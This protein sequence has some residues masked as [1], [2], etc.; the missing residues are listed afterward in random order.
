MP[1]PI[2]HYQHTQVGY[3]VIFALAFGMSLCAG[4]LLAAEFNA[5]ALGMVILLGIC[6]WLFAMLT[7]TVDNRWLTIRFGPGLVR[8]RWPLDD[9][10]DAQVVGNPWYYGWGIHLTPHGWLYNVSG[11]GAAQITLKNGHSFRIGSDEPE[12]LATAIR[13]SIAL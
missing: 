7:V 8:R 3:L 10:I 13:Q 5:I 2:A 4:L 6:L 1:H 12:A 11:M 9:V